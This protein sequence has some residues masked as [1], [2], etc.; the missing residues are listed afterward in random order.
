MSL[1]EKQ[2]SAW[3]HKGENTLEQ[4][5]NWTQG[6]ARS[7]WFAETIKGLDFESVYEVGVFGGRNLRHIHEVRPDV[8]LGGLDINELGVQ[9]AK[10]RFEGQF[11]V[12]SA[13]DIDKVA[14][15]WDIVFTIG[16]SIHL[17]PDLFEQ[18]IGKAI[19][20]ANKYVMHLEQIGDGTIINGPAE[21]KPKAKVT[22]RIRWTPDFDAVYG[23]FGLKPKT[24]PLPKGIRSSDCTHMV[25]V[26]LGRV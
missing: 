19:G 13:F 21:L 11:D 22:N 12:C 1:R 23:N 6:N 14:G 15:S 25:V 3:S 24:T 17:A 18:F 9:H 26:D 10:N 16:V 5:W 4:Y 7:R 2:E 8:A 20:K